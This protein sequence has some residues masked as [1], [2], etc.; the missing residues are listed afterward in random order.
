MEGSVL[1]QAFVPGLSSIAALADDGA[2]AN[3]HRR[4]SLGGPSHHWD[5]D[6]DGPGRLGWERSAGGPGGPGGPGGLGGLGSLGD[7]GGLGSLSLPVVASRLAKSR[8]PRPPLPGGRLKMT[9]KCPGACGL[10]ARERH[11]L[12]LS[13]G[14]WLP[15]RRSSSSRRSIRPQPCLC[16]TNLREKG[17]GPG[18]PYLGPGP[19]TGSRQNPDPRVPMRVHIHS[20]PMSGARRAPK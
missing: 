18:P 12:A 4:G 20:H 1:D 5:R 9:K 8:S 11:R 15:C 14:W 6:D 17:P 3:G 7:K 13:S 10:L 16:S 2:G 19:S